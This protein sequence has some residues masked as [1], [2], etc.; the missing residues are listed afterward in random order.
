MESYSAVCGKSGDSYSAPLLFFWLRFAK[1]LGILRSYRLTVHYPAVPGG[2]RGTATGG[3][4]TY[5]YLY[6]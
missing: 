3:G 4:Y 2:V 6:K 5:Y 1:T